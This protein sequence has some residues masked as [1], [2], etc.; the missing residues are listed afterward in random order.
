MPVDD[1]RGQQVG[2]RLLPIDTQVDQQKDERVVGVLE[3]EA[4]RRLR[5]DGRR[6]LGKERARRDDDESHVGHVETLHV[7]QAARG[8]RQTEVLGERESDESLRQCQVDALLGGHGRSV[9]HAHLVKP[10]RWLKIRTSG[11]TG[12]VPSLRHVHRWRCTWWSPG[13]CG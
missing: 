5:V 3:A 10:P 7:V 2:G 6:V 4:T 12:D 9:G 13:A 11:R 1:D 8:L